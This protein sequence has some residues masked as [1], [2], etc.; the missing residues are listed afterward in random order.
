MIHCKC[1]KKVGIAKQLTLFIYLTIANIPYF[2]LLCT[3]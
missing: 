2:L 3:T 1:T